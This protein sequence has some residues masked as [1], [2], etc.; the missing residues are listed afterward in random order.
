MININFYLNLLKEL[1]YLPYLFEIILFI[2]LIRPRKWEIFTTVILFIPA[3]FY[4]FGQVALFLIFQIILMCFAN[5]HRKYI[6]W[7]IAYCLA[8]IIGPSVGEAIGAMIMFWLEPLLK[9]NL[10]HSVLLTIIFISEI[11]IYLL[12]FCFL[13]RKRFN[14]KQMIEEANENASFLKVV[15]LVIISITLSLLVLEVSLYYSQKSALVVA[16]FIISLVAIVDLI[17]LIKQ[18]QR[19]IKMKVEKAEMK[20]IKEY[21]T[22]LEQVNMSLRKARHD[23][24]NSLLSLNGYLFEDDVSG[25]KKYL[26]ELVNE[27]NRLQKLSKT[28]TLELSNLKVKE[29]KYLIISKLQSAQDQGIK[30]KVEI[31]QTV[32]NLPCNIVSIIRATGILLDNAIEAC[33][34]QEKPWLTVMITRYNKN[35]YSLVVQNSI[36][37]EVNVQEIFKAGFTDKKKHS[38]LGL[39]NID[40]IVKNDPNLSLEVEQQK[41]Q[42]AFE[43]LIQ[44]E[45]A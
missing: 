9:F 11:V 18:N 25:A 28:M 12:F 30:T 10:N 6:G 38:G 32:L 42:I 23:Y 45:N 33:A 13:E 5:F 16:W 20:E 22:R 34:N 39:A 4:P 29:L 8:V 2:F 41:N 17:V 24:K 44:G 31:N 36:M 35:A 7:S 21:S 43:L 15:D 3:L 37:Q 26:G 40:E 14:F 27:N 1:A 19:Y